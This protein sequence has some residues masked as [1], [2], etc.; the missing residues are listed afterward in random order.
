M[1]TPLLVR[2]RCGYNF[3]YIEGVLEKCPKCGGVYGVLP[4]DV[5]LHMEDVDEQKA[6]SAGSI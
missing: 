1:T 3:F 2:C 4:I 5:Y 6:K